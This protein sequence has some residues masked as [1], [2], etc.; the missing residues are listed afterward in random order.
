MS[1][2]VRRFHRWP[3]CAVWLLLAVA[4][5]A[6]AEGCLA[7]EFN[8]FTPYNGAAN[9]V[10][11][12][13]NNP[14]FIGNAR[15]QL[16]SGGT[17]GGT[18]TIGSH[19][20]TDIGVRTA[21]VGAVSP[22]LYHD[23]TYD[24]R[25]PANLAQY[26]PVSDLTF[27][28][29]DVD[30]GDNVTVNAYDQNGTLIALA[31]SNY[32]FVTTDGTPVVSY[33]GANRFT[34]T[35]S[36][37]SDQRGT[38]L[39]NFTGLQVR[40]VVLRYWDVSAAGTYTAAGWGGCNA[41]LVLNKT[42]QTFAGG[43]F[44]FTLT[45]TSRNTGATVS[46][47]AANTP[48]QVDGN[49]TTAGVQAFGITTAGTAVTIQESS[50]PTGWTLN[51]VVCTNVSGT[52]VGSLSGTTY[53][54]PAAATTAGA[55]LTCT[56]TNAPPQADVQVNKTSSTPT[57]ATGQVISYTLIARNNGPA[58]ANGSVLADLAGPGQNCS[59]PSTTATCTATGGAVCPGAT[60]PVATLLGGG[61]T[62]ATFPANSQV[63]FVIQ[64]TVTASGFT[65]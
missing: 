37:V 50:L 33:A 17:A 3:L 18:M 11:T 48:V 55:L 14:I 63:S 54:L 23:S 6:A 32:S 61:V 62:V 43:P 59:A 40:R 13:A 45:N 4:R 34:T 19:F 9:A 7:G 64:C 36:D 30:A 10:T 16:S 57:V 20:A 31:A 47:S 8:P 39:L 21:Q 5:P 38:V 12:V 22:T 51:G 42:T 49:A 24:F 26:L 15:L 58:A 44:G 35:L 56:F 52:S 53:T 60:V 1:S 41:S 46:T 28:L 29:Y 65:P 25:D 2:K 27:V